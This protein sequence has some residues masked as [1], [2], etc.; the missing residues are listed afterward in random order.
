MRKGT[1]CQYKIWKE[2][3][4]GEKPASEKTVQNLFSEDR[5]VSAVD[6][7]HWRWRQIRQK[8][9][10]PIRWPISATFGLFTARRGRVSGN[11]DSYSRK[12]RIQ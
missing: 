1:Q 6:S 12:S 2:D 5:Y 3:T 9:R 8:T 11:P 7:V 4:T 10:N